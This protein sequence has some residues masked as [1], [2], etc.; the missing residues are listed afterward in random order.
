MIEGIWNVL[1]DE[2]NR[3]IL[4]WIGGGLAIAIGALW[5]AYKFHRRDKE[6]KKDSQAAMVSASNKSISVGRDIRNSD[7]EIKNK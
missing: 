4:S 3:S 7:I 5:A 2:G 6:E 1:S